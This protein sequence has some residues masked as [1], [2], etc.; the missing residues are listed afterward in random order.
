M[1][2]F[3][4]PEI[5]TDLYRDLRDRRLLPIAVVLI[6]GLAI[7][8]IALSSQSSSTAPVPPPA[9][10]S[11]PTKSNAPASTVV[12]SNPGLR[13][14]K[15]RLTHGSKNPFTTPGFAKM[16]AS[17]PAS[18]S[19]SA[20]SSTAATSS[21]GGGA[22]PASSLPSSSGTVSSGGSSTP[23]V[24]VESKFYF[25]RVKAKAGQVGQD[26]KAHDN[27][28]TLTVLPDKSAPVAEFLGV[29]TDSSF[30]PVRAV[31]LVNSA[32]T[33]VS[34]TGACTFKG[35]TCQVVSMKP[36]QH[37][38]FVWTDGLSYRIQLIDFNLIVRNKPPA[39]AGQGSSSGG[40]PS[41]A[42]RKAV[43]RYF[44]F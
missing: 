21:A 28:G 14:Y 36:G 19:G 24:K 26:L 18:S 38:D 3:Q 7:V 37:E 10:A 35:T 4:T 6:A 5:L 39:V 8:P 9:V 15:R 23:P 17:S 22:T 11:V 42:G 43:G 20:S 30:K 31:F 41:S 29:V 27:V 16:P 34:G 25:Y 13:D 40:G 1:N 2:N 44:T 12:V 32:V 33:A